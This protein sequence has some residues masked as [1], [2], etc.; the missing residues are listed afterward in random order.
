[1]LAGHVSDWRVDSRWPLT[2]VTFGI[3]GMCA[4]PSGLNHFFLALPSLRLGLSTNGPLALDPETLPRPDKVY[5][6]L[7]SLVWD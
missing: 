2:N 5:N 4:A 3:D 1:M 7:G 6:S